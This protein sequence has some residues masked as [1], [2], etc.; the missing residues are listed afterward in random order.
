[1]IRIGRRTSFQSTS[2]SVGKVLEVNSAL[3]ERGR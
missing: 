1:M 2:L 3:P